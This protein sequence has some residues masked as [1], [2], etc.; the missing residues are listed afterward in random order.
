MTG[1][2]RARGGAYPSN[3]G[4]LDSMYALLEGLEDSV[5]EISADR[6]EGKLPRWAR[7]RAKDFFGYNVDFLPLAAGATATNTIAVQ[8]DSDFMIVEA[9]IFIGDDPLTTITDPDN[10]LLLVLI[11]DSGSGRDLMDQPAPVANYF[12]TAQ[13]PGYLPYPKVIRRASTLSTQLQNLDAVNAQ[14]VRISYLGFKVFDFPA[15]ALPGTY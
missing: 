4:P 13:R 14:N 8:N 9:N 6:W 11:K 10:A 7:E 15:N 3:G 5:Q 1:P 2:G 12:G